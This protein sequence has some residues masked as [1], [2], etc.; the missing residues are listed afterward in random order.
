MAMRYCLIPI[1]FKAVSGSLYSKIGRLLISLITIKFPSF[2]ILAFKRFLFFL[3]RKSPFL[4]IGWLSGC[5]VFCMRLY[6][7]SL[8][9]VMMIATLRANLFCASILVTQWSLLLIFHERLYFLLF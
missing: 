9:I 8:T 1:R 5:S 7:E 4:M 3:V 2:C 6:S